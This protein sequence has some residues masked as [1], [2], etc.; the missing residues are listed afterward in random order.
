MATAPAEHPIRL[1]VHDDL[2]R[3]RLTVAFR[4]VLGI[5][6]L[7]WLLLW[8]LAA[9]VVTF[10]LWIAILIEGKAPAILHD[11]VAG[12]VRYATHVGAYLFLSAEQYPSFR[13]SPGYAVDVEIDPPARQGRLGAFF[14][15]LL[16]LPALMLAATLGGGFAWSGAS[17]LSTFGIALAYAGTGVAGTAALLMWFAAIVRGRSP[18]GLRDLTA[19]ALGYG[20]QA[21]GYMLL[22]TSRYPSCDPS[23]VEP[24]PE[25]PEH[26][27]RIAVNEELER[28]RLTIFF[29][30]LLAIPH[31][32]WITL[33]S[34]LVPFAALVAWIIALIRARVPEK[35]HR[36]LAAYVRYAIHL[37]AYLYVVGRRFP[38]FTGRQGT[39]GIDVEI[40]PP[41]RQ[42]RW[43]T[44]FRIFL[45][46]PALLVASALGSALFVVA[47]LGWWVSLVLGRM[48]EG[49]R[50]LGA[51][52][53]RYTA[54]TYSYCLLVTDGYPYAS[55]VLEG[56]TPIV[57]SP[58][59]ILVGDAF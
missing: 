20:A 29:R 17:A 19:Y 57:A 23:L 32:V 13:G 9:N 59:E 28:S 43:K 2:R 39:Y 26:P 37:G 27:V 1:V 49:L 16:V 6:L 12:Y 34:I 3:R 30:L 4:F 46:I 24:L 7:V 52:C 31:I 56:R 55:P 50:N 5:P 14:R 54:Q 45:A 35:L 58:S 8:G 51:S 11:F 25:L 44:L 40:D 42:N 41:E 10:L 33:W 21:G 36:F 48:P 18:Q 47:V 22:L 53:L 38:G 15:L